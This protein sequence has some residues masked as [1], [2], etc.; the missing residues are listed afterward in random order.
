MRDHI[1]DSHSQ[2]ALIAQI[3][4][5]AALDAVGA[6]AAVEGIDG[7][8]IGR[9]DLAVAMG[10]E[11]AAAEVDAAAASICSSAIAAGIAVGIF[12]ANVSDAAE[13]ARWRAAGASLFLVGSDQSFVLAGAKG[14]AGIFHDHGRQV[15]QAP[16]A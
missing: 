3:E 7:V 15:S 10:K 16:D 13:I 2:T 8:F 1:H 9:A 14:L 5:P 12:V 11:L 6:I 4:D